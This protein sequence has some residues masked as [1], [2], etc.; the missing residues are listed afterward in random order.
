MATQTSRM[1]GRMQL[2]TTSYWLVRTLRV[3]TSRPSAQGTFSCLVLIFTASSH[4]GLKHPSNAGKHTVFFRGENTVLPR[5]SMKDPLRLRE[6]TDARSRKVQWNASTKL[7]TTARPAPTS[8]RR[9]PPAASAPVHDA[10][11][12]DG[13]R[14][15]IERAFE[16]V[17]ARDV[18]GH[19]SSSP[20]KPKLDVV[21]APLSSV[22]DRRLSV[23]AG[24]PQ[25]TTEL[26]QLELERT[27]RKIAIQAFRAH[28]E[29]QMCR[30]QGML[31]D[32]ASREARMDAAFDAV[33]ASL[34]R[35]CRN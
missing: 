10:V 9:D 35:S 33:A 26:L 15:L 1:L 31:D 20:T 3:H 6:E 30:L 23:D 29:A 4:A 19:A 14:R 34:N 17:W 18:A 16:N 7:T 11:D 28:V 12:D 25:R 32:V 5:R 27:Q 2:V 8:P 13:A 22:V 24:P 21:D